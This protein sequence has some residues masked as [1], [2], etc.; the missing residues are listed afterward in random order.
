MFIKAFS[1]AIIGYVFIYAFLL[2]WQAGMGHYIP[3]ER[4]VEGPVAHLYARLGKLAAGP[5]RMKFSLLLLAHVPDGIPLIMWGVSAYLCTVLWAGGIWETLFARID[6][7]LPPDKARLLLIACLLL[8]IAMFVLARNAARTAVCGLCISTGEKKKGQKERQSCTSLRYREEVLL[9]CSFW[10]FFWPETASETADREKN[11]FPVRVVS[12]GIGDHA[13]YPECTEKP[14]VPFDQA[15][16]ACGDCEGKYGKHGGGAY[17]AEGNDYL[18]GRGGLEEAGPFRVS[19]EPPRNGRR[20][21]EEL[22]FSE[23]SEAVFFGAD[24]NDA[25]GDPDQSASK[26]MTDLVEKRVQVETKVAEGELGRGDKPEE[27]R[28]D[29]VDTGRSLKLFQEAKEQ[30]IKNAETGRADYS[31]QDDAL[32][33]IWYIILFPVYSFFLLPTAIRS[34]FDWWADRNIRR[35]KSKTAVALSFVGWVA[36]WL[37][38]AYMMGV[39]AV[40]ICWLATKF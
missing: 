28:G 31:E 32:L 14:D 7:A 34:R 39:A 30:P 4:S 9:P 27:Q 3:W 26:V 2:P 17:S 18:F 6:G 13:G 20:A 24:L 1:W 35:D 15:A 40:I 5:S 37:A 8:P 16:R 19:Y 38:E 33:K 12:G 10:Q 22:R 21:K 29:P 23:A 36:S 25:G 11:P